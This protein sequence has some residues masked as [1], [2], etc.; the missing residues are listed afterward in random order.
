MSE[1]K[2]DVRESIVEGDE[3]VQSMERRWVK[4]RRFVYNS[5]ELK[6]MEERTG[7]TGVFQYN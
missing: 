4:S 5:R 3:T 7:K 1:V 2:E 6:T